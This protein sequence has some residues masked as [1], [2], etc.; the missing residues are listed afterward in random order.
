MYRRPCG[1][2]KRKPPK[3]NKKTLLFP[4]VGLTQSGPRTRWGKAD[5]CVQWSPQLWMWDVVFLRLQI[6]DFGLVGSELRN[7]SPWLLRRGSEADRL[8]CR[9]R[10]WRLRARGRAKDTNQSALREPC[11]DQI[12]RFLGLAFPAMHPGLRPT[13]KG[14]Q[15]PRGSECRE[16]TL[17]LPP[18]WI[19]VL[20]VAGDLR[21]H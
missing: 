16:P 21:P 3:Q 13:L 6:R 20:W 1:L 18:F 7:S 4:R 15:F 12:P 10:P 2:L 17:R 11:A 9:V 8:G 5:V 14:R 19:L